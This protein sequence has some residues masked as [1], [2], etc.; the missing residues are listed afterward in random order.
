MSSPLV[1]ADAHDPESA[2]DS[3]PN[4]DAP[5][6]GGVSCIRLQNAW[7]N[8]WRQELFAPAEA[9]LGYC[10][11]LLEDTR[12]S[13]PP[14]FQDDVAKV[15]AEA[16]KLLAL[17]ESLLDAAHMEAERAAADR[18]QFRR[19]MRHD[20]RARPAAIIGICELAIDEAAELLL[21]KFVPDLQRIQEAAQA[22]I[23]SIDKLVTFGQTPPPGVGA[24]PICLPDQVQAL[25]P[26]PLRQHGRLLIVDDNP[27]SRR[28]LEHVFR[29]QGHEVAAVADG[30]AALDRIAQD[31]FDVVLLDLV[32][33]G[34]SGF[35]VLDQLKANPATRQLPVIVISALNEVDSVIRCIARGADDYLSRPFN[36]LLLTARVGACLEKKRLLDRQAHNL[37]TI[38]RLLHAIVPAEVV[39]ELKDTQTL[40]PRRHERVGVLFL[41]I[42]GFTRYCDGHCPEEVVNRLQDLVLAF[43][44][45]AA[46][47]GVQKIKTI[48]D[49]FMAAAGLLQPDPNPVLTLVSCGQAMIDAAA[50]LSA[51]RD[52]RWDV[53]IGIHAGPVVAGVL[54]RT[55]FAYDLWGDTVNK[56]ARMESASEPGRI[57][58]STE[59]WADVADRCDGE[60]VVLPV[61]SLGDRQRVVRFRRFK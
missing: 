20:L 22:V 1:S 8:H 24:V 54:G 45:V 3:G 60:V 6:P 9:L 56:A 51:G 40:R 15:H 10:T 30:Q 33:P 23:D 16:V 42:V 11:T 14:A 5:P 4:P 18:E 61:K 21:E 52:S 46:A 53:R 39:P 55:Q 31:S 12:Q 26:D 34:L 48:G 13:G 25:P 57:T 28:Y 32:M 36:Q 19:K 2:L 58:L 41:D 44:S 37:K 17:V 7:R 38:D 43:E 59:A 49:A 47:H 50:R 35:D 27:N 29:R